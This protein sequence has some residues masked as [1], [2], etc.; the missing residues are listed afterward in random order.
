MGTRTTKTTHGY[1]ETVRG[2][3]KK[4]PKEIPGAA[5]ATSRRS[6]SKYDNFRR[7]QFREALS[8]LAP[9]WHWQAREIGEN[10]GSYSVKKRYRQAIHWPGSCPESCWHKNISPLPQI[11]GL[12][13][14]N[15]NAY[16]NFSAAFSF[17]VLRRRI[18]GQS[19]LLSTPPYAIQKWYMSQADLGA[20]ARLRVCHKAFVHLLC[21]S[22][23]LLPT[24]PPTLLL[25]VTMPSK[26]LVFFFSAVCGLGAYSGPWYFCPL[27][28]YDPMNSF[29]C[30][31][32]F[33]HRAPCL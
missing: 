21:Y 14:R 16:P 17:E 4:F 19:L 2:E 30:S 5:P 3:R 24:V 1:E 8:F 10:P 23:A 32:K 20:S 12:T 9:T 22:R 18:L 11:A 33:F 13:L 15:T 28:L 31:L 27:S 25:L 29:F 7:L 26:L 6:T